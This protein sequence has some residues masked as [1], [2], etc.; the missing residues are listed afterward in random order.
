MD[1][2]WPME[3][4]RFSSLAPSRLS[5]RGF[6]RAGVT[7]SL[8]AGL[9]ALRAAEPLYR[10]GLGRS[11]DPYEAT[12][13][14]IEASGEFSALDV[15][16]RLVVIK[17]N[18]VSGSPADSGATTDPEVVRAIVDLLLDG[19]A[20]KIL[21][22]E[23]GVSGAHF[24]ETGY[25]SF[26]TYDPQQRVL[27]VDLTQVTSHLIPIPG[28]IYRAIY[29]Y[30]F[31]VSRNVLFVSV[32][33]LKTHGE[34]LATLSTKN[35]F[36]LPDVTR[37][38]SSPSVGRF[39]MHDRGVNQAIIDL[40]LLRPTDFAVVD[41]IWGMEGNGPLSGAPV[42]MDTVI[43]GR[44]AVAV[45]RVCLGLM[46][47]P[48]LAVRHLN[49]ASLLGMGPGSLNQIEVTGD[50]ATPRQ[51]TLPVT[52]PS[53]DPPLIS[54]TVFQP[55]SQ[56]CRVSIQFGTP[57]YCLVDVL[58]VHDERPDVDH[59]RSLRPLAFRDRGT[60]VLKWDGRADDGSLVAPGRY[61]IHVRAHDPSFLTRHG[62]AIGW[63][64]AI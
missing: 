49:Y 31:V 46:K 17:P 11:S 63:V 24:N 58:L 15:A 42:S 59:V 2:Q 54:P 8:L 6:V 61:A 32:A 55:G 3:H 10:V 39:A 45:D 21:I 22:V 19:G 20:E 51:F 44:N 4:N 38:V 16:G 56:T 57:C 40:N 28:W 41:G 47:I 1:V 13:R 52:P 7:G 48:Q 18:L 27:L 33:K 12:M 35:V 37:Y 43:A 34:A 53:F 5:R 62:D 26:N 60:E 29:S 50:S 36:G 30:R 14:A 23:S 64:Y 9:P 25:G